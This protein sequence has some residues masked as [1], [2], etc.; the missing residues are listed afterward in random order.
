MLIYYSEN[1]RYFFKGKNLIRE[2]NNKNKLGDIVVY[3]SEDS[4]RNIFKKY[5]L[6]PKNQLHIDFINGDQMMGEL[7]K[8][9]IDDAKIGGRFFGL[10]ENRESRDYSVFYTGKI[11]KI[12]GEKEEIDLI[13]EKDIKLEGSS[14]LNF[15]V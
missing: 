1:S 2:G 5:G 9:T 8:K 10:I 13:E 11:I 4:I 15:K 14:E 7:E 12:E 3:T 6:T